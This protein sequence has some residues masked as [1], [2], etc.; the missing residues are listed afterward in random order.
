MQ[1]KKNAGATTSDNKMCEDKNPRQKGAVE[2]QAILGIYRV[3]TKLCPAPLN[4][5]CLLATVTPLSLEP[6]R[7]ARRVATAFRAASKRWR[8]ASFSSACTTQQRSHRVSSPHARTHA[9]T[10]TNTCTHAHTHARSVHRECAHAVLKKTFEVVEQGGLGTGAGGR[11][12][13]DH[14]IAH[15]M[16][17]AS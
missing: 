2:L 7:R 17:P 10:N 1:K 14:L 5:W 13:S 3:H 6:K 15:T 9:N 12:R 16:L 8:Y 4:C 11:S